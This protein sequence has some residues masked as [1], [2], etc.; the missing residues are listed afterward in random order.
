MSVGG[1]TE[2]K[3][4]KQFEFQEQK[5]ILQKEINLS[6]LWFCR[7]KWK[8]STKNWFSKLKSSLEEFHNFPLSEQKNKTRTAF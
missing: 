8:K 7:P 1:I 2:K 5:I 6:Y 4:K 3:R